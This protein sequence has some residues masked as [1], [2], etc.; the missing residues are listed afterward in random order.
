MR[1]RTPV[2]RKVL[3]PGG[4]TTPVRR[5]SRS[6]QRANS[7]SSMLWATAEG[8]RLAATW[9]VPGLLT[10]RSSTR[11]LEVRHRTSQVGGQLGQVSDGLG[12]LARAHRGLRRDVLNHV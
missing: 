9:L 12:R 4:T 5:S 7:P 1:E 8:S 3:R 6:T 11:Q 2:T 10:S